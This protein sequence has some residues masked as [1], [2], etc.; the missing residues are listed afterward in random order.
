[1]I[2]NVNDDYVVEE[3]TK[4]NIKKCIGKLKTDK[5]AILE[6][7]DEHFMQIYI[8]EEAE[9]SVIE[10]H[11]AEQH[12]QSPVVDKEATVKAFSLF[13]VGNEKFKECLPWMPA[14]IYEEEYED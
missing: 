10:Y 11:E 12:F 7:D 14:V 13:L 9:E 3:V 5:F 8:S 2:L 6:K 4:A 1:M